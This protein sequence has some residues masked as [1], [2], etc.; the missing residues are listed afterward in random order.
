[1]APFE[2][3]IQTSQQNVTIVRKLF[4]SPHFV[5]AIKKMDSH[6]PTLAG[7]YK[8][9]ML[10]SLSRLEYSKEE[11]HTHKHTHNFGIKGLE[12]GNWVKRKTNTLTH[13]RFCRSLCEIPADFSSLNRRIIK[14]NLRRRHNVITLYVKLV[15]VV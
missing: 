7:D 13:V 10:I 8:G 9:G 4:E 2:M 3:R 11:R 6:P 1:M 14:Q 15:V 12:S 5:R